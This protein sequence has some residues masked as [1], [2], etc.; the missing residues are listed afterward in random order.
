MNEQLQLIGKVLEFPKNANM[1]SQKYLTQC[2]NAFDILNMLI[3]DE[4]DFAIVVKKKD[5][6][7]IVNT[8]IKEDD[9]R[10]FIVLQTDKKFI[11]GFHPNFAIKIKIDEE[12]IY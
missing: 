6:H 5:L 12:E 7:E 11:N 9:M 3:S 4:A 8:H 10:D 1:E 2:Q